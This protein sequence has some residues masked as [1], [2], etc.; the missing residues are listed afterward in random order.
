MPD[1][2]KEDTEQ[3]LRR[4]QLEIVRSCLLR[5]AVHRGVY[6]WSMIL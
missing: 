5:S 3:R 1:T 2:L 6:G 4:E